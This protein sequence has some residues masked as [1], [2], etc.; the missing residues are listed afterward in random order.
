M[1]FSSSAQMTS[2]SYGL[3]SAS[4]DPYDRVPSLERDYVSVCYPLLGALSLIGF[5]QCSNFTCCGLHLSDL[6]SLVDHF[7][8]AHVVVFDS[9]GYPIFPRTDLQAFDVGEYQPDPPTQ[10]TGHPMT[11]LVV[12]YPQ[13]DPSTYGTPTGQEVQSHYHSEPSSPLSVESPTPSAYYHQPTILDHVGYEHEPSVTFDASSQA[14]PT[15]LN[16]ANTPN[17]AE[18]ELSYAALPPSSF[19]VESQYRRGDTYTFT[20][21]QRAHKSSS[22]NK[23][24]PYPRRREKAHKCPVCQI[25]IL[26]QHTVLI[27]FS[28]HV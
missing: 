21:R 14:S 17:H 6:H 19:V 23:P 28:C 27:I 15:N 9:A 16:H 11:S 2:R 20:H 12:S 5:P 25:S 24:R 4:P 13:P 7:E 26:R 18:S 8:Q 1:H 3:Y 22:A 10:L